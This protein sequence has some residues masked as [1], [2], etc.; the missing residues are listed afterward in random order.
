MY[1]RQFNIEAWIRSY[2]NLGR[3]RAL[4]IKKGLLAMTREWGFSA[5]SLNLALD[6]LDDVM[7]T[8]L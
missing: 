7:Y 6:N 2:F 4:V 5:I 3:R 8:S 1:L